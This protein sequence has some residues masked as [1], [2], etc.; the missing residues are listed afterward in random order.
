MDW[1]AAAAENRQQGRICK[2]L[3]R[4]S[5]YEKETANGLPP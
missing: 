1:A 4:A 5:P 2:F 3:E